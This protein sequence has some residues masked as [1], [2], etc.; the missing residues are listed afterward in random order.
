MKFL[1]KG[2]S[3]LID[4]F[5]TFL[6]IISYNFFNKNFLFSSKTK[7]K[8]Y[9]YKKLKK[10]LIECQKNVP[11]Y[12]QLFSEINFN[13]HSDFLTLEDLQ[14]IPILEKDTLIAKREDFIN[15]RKKHFYIKTKTS[16][17]SGEPFISYVSYTHWIVEQAVIWRQWKSFGY[18]FRDSM[19]IIRSFSPKDGEP[20]IKHDRIRNFTYYSPYHL[21]D[22]NMHDYYKDMISRKIKFLRGYPSSLK[23]FASFCKKHDLSIPNLKGIFLA[24]ETLN[25]N[26]RSH[27]KNTFN[28]PIINHYGLAECVVMFGSLYKDN[29]LYNYDE[30]GFLEEIKKSNNEFEVVGTN[31]NNHI[32]P[33]VRFNTRDKIKLNCGEDSNKSRINFKKIKSIIGRGNDVIKTKDKNIPLTNIYTMM[34]K[35][36]EIT[37]WQIVQKKNLDLTINIKCDFKSELKIKKILNSKLMILKEENLDIEINI[38]SDFIRTGEGKIPVFLR[39]K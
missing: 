8:N 20:L 21:S 24:S 4:I 16:G 31:L 36:S 23:I 28:A 32:M 10:L 7:I 13:P 12:K 14:K 5:L 30:Y 27:I 1:I 11:Y 34:A 39:C 33:L 3:K 38:N 17:T 29:H 26:D 15:V 22:K 6:G 35:I 9:Q 37:Q 19:A 25:S 18:K 2:Y